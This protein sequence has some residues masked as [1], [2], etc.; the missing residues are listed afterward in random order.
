MYYDFY[1]LSFIRA[2][3]RQVIF[4]PGRVKVIFFFTKFDINGTLMLKAYTLSSIIKLYAL[5]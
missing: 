1:L 5:F 2:W 3:D 4:S